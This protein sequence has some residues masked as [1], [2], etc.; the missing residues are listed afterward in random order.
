MHEDR[1]RPDRGTRAEEAD[2]LQSDREAAERRQAELEAAGVPSDEA[3]QVIDS[4][5]RWPN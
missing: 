3:K 1:T 4:G 2:R 5:L